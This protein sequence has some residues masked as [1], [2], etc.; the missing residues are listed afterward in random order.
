MATYYDA[1]N[2]FYKLN[3]QERF[4]SSAQLIYLHLLHINNRS[5]NRGYVQVSDRELETMTGFAKQSITRV[6]QILKNRGLIEFKTD[7]RNP[8]AGTQYT[9]NFFIQ[10]QSVGQSVGQ[11]IGQSLGQSVGQSSRINTQPII[12]K[13][14]TKDLRIR[15]QNAGARASANPKVSDDVF[16]VWTDEMPRPLTASEKYEL[17]DLEERHGFEKVKAAI[18]ATRRDRYY[19]T[20]ANFKETLEGKKKGVEK[21]EQREH[22]YA[23]PPEYEF[24]DEWEC[25]SANG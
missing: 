15:P 20:F 11:N 6:K 1:L 9:L 3:E 24:L 18:I 25:E 17:A 5:G 4:V 14:K 12:S 23:K 2:D 19:P 10:G 21:F 22:Q 7:K 8:R 16:K 13:E